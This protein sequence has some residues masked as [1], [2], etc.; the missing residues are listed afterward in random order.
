MTTEGKYIYCIIGTSDPRHF[1][2]IGIGERNDEVTTIGARDISAIVSNTPMEKYVVSR[3]NL[4][5]HE[6]I[7]EKV[8]SE[9]TVLPVRF[10]TVATSTQEVMDCLKRRYPE[11]K[12]LLR[13][14]DNK[15]EVGLK[16]VW[17]DMQTVFDELVAENDDIRQMKEAGKIKK[18]NDLI[19]A[20]KIVEA[21][22]EEKR[23]MEEGR[24]FRDL[25]K[26]AS[27]FKSAKRHGDNMLTNAAFLLDKG[28]QRA[29]DNQVET[30]VEENKDRFTVNY[31]GP[32]PPFN[33]V[34]IEIKFAG[35]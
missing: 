1:G 22:L 2:P 32:A 5:A 16:V 11:F 13:D 34:N 12:N 31:V 33:F 30:L 14:M 28:R 15:V 8:M 19:N 26:V 21:I 6:K 25:K 29:F 4:T 20:G 27:D 7:I 3:E 18:R 17:N 9:Y 10:C 24:L 35:E 23:S